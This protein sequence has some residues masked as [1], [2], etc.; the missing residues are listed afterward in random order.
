MKLNSRPINGGAVN[1][2]GHGRPRRHLALFAQGRLVARRVSLCEVRRWATAQ[3][4]SRRQRFTSKCLSARVHCQGMT[5]KH[6]FRFWFAQAGC[7]AAR[8][9]CLEARRVARLR[10]RAQGSKLIHVARYAWCRTRAWRHHLIDRWI[11]TVRPVRIKAQINQGIRIVNE[12]ER[13]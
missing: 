7:T 10:L 6:F 5:L 13:G 2:D 11:A 4:Q 9:L 12:R 8:E 3:A 1:G